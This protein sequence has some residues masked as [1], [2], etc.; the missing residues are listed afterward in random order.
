MTDLSMK[1]TVF[2]TFQTPSLKY[3]EFGDASHAKSPNSWPIYIF[4]T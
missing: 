3:N 2:V 1:N 4:G